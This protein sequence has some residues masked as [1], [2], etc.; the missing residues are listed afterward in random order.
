MFTKGFT[1]FTIVLKTTWDIMTQTAEHSRIF[2]Q[3]HMPYQMPDRLIR[4]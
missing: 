1:A 2:P 4:K 3:H